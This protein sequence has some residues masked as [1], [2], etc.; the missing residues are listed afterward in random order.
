MD[1]SLTQSR[2]AT[3]MN[4]V[5]RHVRERARRHQGDGQTDGRLM[6]RFLAARDEA[7]LPKSILLPD[8]IL[9]FPRRS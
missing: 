7:E 8:K 3:G 9:L 2:G 4:A 1:R 5:L 6:E